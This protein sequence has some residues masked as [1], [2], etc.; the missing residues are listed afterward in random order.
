MPVD[1]GELPALDSGA[2]WDITNAPEYLARRKED[3]WVR[4]WK[5]KQSLRKAL[6]AL[7]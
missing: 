1:W 2:H 3:P 4:Y 6:A 5:N 7:R